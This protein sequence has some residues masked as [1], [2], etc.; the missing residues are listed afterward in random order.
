MKF[1]KRTPYYNF[2]VITAFSCSVK[3]RRSTLG[4]GSAEDATTLL[5]N[6]GSSVWSKRYD[7][8]NELV[9]MANSRP[10]LITAH[11]VKVRVIFIKVF[12][13]DV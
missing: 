2:S 13:L 6:M 5:D 9:D 4:I 11:T 3:N 7:S 8:V 1:K 12:L 10:R